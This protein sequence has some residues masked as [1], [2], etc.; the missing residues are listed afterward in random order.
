MNKFNNPL[1]TPFAKKLRRK[2]TD[3]EKKLWYHFL[4]HLPMTVSR[5]KVIGRYVVD[6]YISSCSLAIEIDGHSH[7]T[8]D[9]HSKDDRRSL[10]LSS[11]GITIIR[12]SNY[13]VSYRFSHVCNDISRHIF[14]NR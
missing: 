2:M 1:L 12:Y 3:E 8:Y 11:M 4:V 9:G 5:Q 10:Y 7:Y 14:R 13:D 6:F